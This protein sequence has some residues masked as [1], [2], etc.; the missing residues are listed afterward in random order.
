MSNEKITLTAYALQGLIGSL[1]YV[2]D[3]HRALLKSALMI[4]QAR[5]SGLTER[6]VKEMLHYLEKA[7]LI[8]QGNREAVLKK[9]FAST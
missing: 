7:H 4:L 8:T 2:D 1:S 3:Q 6:D 9:L 5:K